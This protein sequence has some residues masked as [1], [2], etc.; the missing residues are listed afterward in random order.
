MGLE[1]GLGKNSDELSVKAGYSHV[2]LSISAAHTTHGGLA[3]GG[4]FGLSTSTEIGF[5]PYTDANGDKLMAKRTVDGRTN[6]TANIYNVSGGAKVT[7]DNVVSVKIN[8]NWLGVDQ[9]QVE[10]TLALVSFTS[11]NICKLAGRGTVY[12][13]GQYGGVYTTDPSGKYFGDSIKTV[14]GGDDFAADSAGG[15]YLPAGQFLGALSVRVHAA[16]QTYTVSNDFNTG[17]QSLK[18]THGGVAMITA[19]LG[20]NPTDKLIA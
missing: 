18:T 1:F 13:G 7:S 10:H 17:Y 11:S 8:S 14:T 5:N 4:K 19:G 16:N 2:A 15:D 6:I 20:E 12:G 9:G 3:F